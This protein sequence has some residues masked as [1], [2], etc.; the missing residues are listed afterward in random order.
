[1]CYSL[2][3]SVI[4]FTLMNACSIF[5]FFFSDRL[6]WLGPKNIRDNKVVAVVLSGASTMQIA[7]IL[8][9]ASSLEC[10]DLN[11][12]GSRFGLLSLQVIQPC[13]SLIATVIGYRYQSGK[14]V[15]R[16][17]DKFWRESLLVTYA[18]FIVMYA[19]FTATYWPIENPSE[20]CTT[21]KRDCGADG[22]CDLQW[23]WA[24]N[25]AWQYIPY[26][27]TVFVIPSLSIH[28]WILGIVATFAFGPP[29][30]FVTMGIVGAS[31]SCFW[32]PFLA[33]TLA[34][35]VP[36]CQNKPKEIKYES[37]NTEIN[38]LDL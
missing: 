32:A 19:V 37:V 25:E 1:M 10:T 12:A 21:Q 3:A 24:P 2:E 35:A 34:L 6:P 14:G 11:R 31:A 30:Y 23:D 18:V 13:F 17:C 36:A 4:G 38:R 9:H 22:I 33:I 26:W 7:E 15:M 29:L 27:V 16:V 28:N 5:L 20:W 8:I